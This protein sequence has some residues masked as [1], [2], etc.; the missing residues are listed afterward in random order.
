MVYLSP[1]E[2]ALSSKVKAVDVGLQHCIAVSRCGYNV[3]TWG[4]ALR[5][6]LGISIMSEERFATPQLVGGMDG[7][8]V[9]VS[10]GLNHSAAVTSSGA[11]YLWG[12][13]MSKTE[14]AENKRGIINLPNLVET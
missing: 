11:V 9:G 13:G 12:K 8:V 5:G 6:Q 1:Q 7:M 10:A 4:K 14:N 3:F 2:V